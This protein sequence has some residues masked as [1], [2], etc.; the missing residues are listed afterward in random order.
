M[1]RWVR[2]PGTVVG[3]FHVFRVLKHDMARDGGA[4]LPIY[5]LSGGD[6]C[7]VVPITREG[8]LVLIKQHRFGTNASSIEI[9]GGVIDPGEEPIVAARRELLEETGYQC[10]DLVP[11]G[12]LHPNPA[13]QA[14]RIHMFLARGCRPHAAGQAL[15]ELEDCEVMVVDRAELEA[16]LDR[17]EIDHALIWAALHAFHRFEQRELRERG[18]RGER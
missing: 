9:P 17:G 3:D 16:L 18:E 5:T 6:W 13:L 15:E 7:N 2:S 4:P 14:N 12:V 1:A 11:L 8:Q 10:D